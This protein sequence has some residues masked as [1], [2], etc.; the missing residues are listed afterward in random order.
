[1]TDIQSE[2]IEQL[3]DKISNDSSLPDELKISFLRLQM[4]LHKLSLSDPDFISNSQHPARRTLFIAKR[5]SRL[6]NNDS[7]I[8]NKINIILSKLFSS[9]PD[10][11][12]FSDINLQLNKLTKLL[13]LNYKN[14][15]STTDLKKLLNLKIKHC[16]QGYNI[17]GQCHKLIF[18]LWPAALFYLLKTYG[19]N[20]V[21][22]SNAINMYSELL[23]SIQ[24]INNNK[25]PGQHRNDFMNIVRSNNNMLL[26]YHQEHKVEAAIKS[27]I[28]HYNQVS[29]DSGISNN[30]NHNNQNNIPEKISSLPKSVKPG[31]WC[32]I[33]INDFTPPRRLR[34][35]VVHMETGMLTFV[36]RKGVKKLEKDAAEFSEEIDLGLSKIYKHDALFTNTPS[37]AQ[38][39]KIG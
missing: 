20:S 21:Q 32:E 17:P 7:Q 28:N 30:S 39:K 27:L 22:W 31:V 11:D 25:L 5:L 10:T 26:L 38:F 37:K 29:D 19:D 23:D 35:S 12:K 2:F 24:Y 3:F 6:S 36:N 34:L 16:T 4:P 9:D 33:F 1:M 13:Q 18:N 15:P 8:I 14:E